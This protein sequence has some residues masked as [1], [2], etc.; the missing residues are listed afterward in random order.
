MSVG[1]NNITDIRV[2][3]VAVEFDNSKAQQGPA[4]QPFQTLIMGQKRSTGTATALAVVTVTSEAQARTLFGAGSMLQ[5]MVKRYLQN[6]LVTTLQVVPIV[7]NAAGV[8]ATGKVSIVGPATADGV[9]SIY[10][11]GKKIQTSV[12]SGDVA[13]AVATALAAA[14]NA[15]TDAQVTAAVNGSNLFEVDISA[16]H[17]GTMGN[18]IDIRLNYF[19][20]DLTPA[21]LAITLTAMASG[22]GDPDTNT[23]FAALPEE[24]YNVVINPWN[25]TSNMTKLETELDSRFGPMKAI[26]SV[27]FT[28]KLGSLGT[29][30][31]Y[32]NARNNSHSCILGPCKAAPNPSWEWSSATG[33]Q[34]AK[35]AQIDPARPFT[36][37][38]LVGI[39]AP[40]KSDEF[41]MS[42]RNTLLTDGIASTKI[43]IGIPQ[44]ERL[45]TS[46]QV[47]AASQ[48]DT[49][50]LDATTLFTLSYLRYSFRNRMASKFPRHK[51]AND[52]TRFG[53]GQPVITPSI[54]KAEAISLFGEWERA[55]LVEGVDQFTRD[56]VIERNASNPN[57]IDCLLPPDLVNQLLNVAAQIQFLL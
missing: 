56:L 27:S 5:W 12:T 15:D 17:K 13:T 28:T 22:A 25:D 57:R 53:P 37:L 38:P 30:S 7:D 47:N 26:D 42:E 35:S 54:A 45:I 31:S 46:Y 48:P 20:E 40:N 21:G 16:R 23:I 51:L 50:Y 24:Q 11:A 41:I 10:F 34:A 43:V 4:I 1:F 8:I 44:I 39:L 52:G 55:G 32:G 19:A 18:Q 9:L 49:S 29:L 2:P 6:D 36:T 14:I 3:F 33:G